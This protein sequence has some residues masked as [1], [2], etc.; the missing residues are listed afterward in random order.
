MK[1]FIA[2]SGG[3]DPFHI[4]HLNLLEDAAKLGP[5]T[6]F[7]N[8]DEW[9][10]RK[11]GFVFMPFRE[12]GDILRSIRYVD[13]VRGPINHTAEGLRELAPFIFA[14]ANGGDRTEPDPEEA[15]VCKLHSIYMLFGVGGEKVQ[16]SSKLVEQV[17]K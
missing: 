16:S 13:S 9:L 1:K 12:R 17:K 10:I 14:F 5:V 8:S 7:L 11:K 2:V 4:G 3:F 6:V 15:A